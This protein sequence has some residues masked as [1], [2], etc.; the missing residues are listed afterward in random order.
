MFWFRYM[1]KKTIERIKIA[2][3]ILPAL[4]CQVEKKNNNGTC[5]KGS[6]LK[7]ICCLKIS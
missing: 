5:I 1:L 4:V 3:A 6:L 7:T 2:G